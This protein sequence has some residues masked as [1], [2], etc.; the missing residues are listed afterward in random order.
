MRAVQPL[1]E[2]DL[3]DDGGRRAA[4]VAAY[5]T[6]L[7]RVDLL[8]GPYASGLVRALVPL[9]R[10]AG[11]LLWNHGG[12]ADDLAQ[13]GAGDGERC[14][15][16]LLGFKGSVWNSTPRTLPPRVATA[17]CSASQASSAWAWLASDQPISRREGRSSTMVRYS[18][19]SVTRR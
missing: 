14:R 17:A 9:V 3:L 11:Q 10:E 1:G 12:S 15:G 18:K 5:S 2:V 19:R 8:I 6:W 4:A 16:V 7:G 13:P